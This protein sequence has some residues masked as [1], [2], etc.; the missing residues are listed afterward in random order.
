ML[1]V[2]ECEEPED[3]IGLLRLVFI[4]RIRSDE[5]MEK[6]DWF[7]I[8]TLLEIVDV[9]GYENLMPEQ[10]VY[11]A[12]RFAAAAHVSLPVKKRRKTLHPQAFVVYWLYA[13]GARE[14]PLYVGV[15]QN[16]GK[17][18]AAHRIGSQQTKG[19]TDLRTLRIAVVATV[20][21]SWMDAVEEESRQIEMAAIINPNL[22]NKA[23]R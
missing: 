21:G 2:E 6:I 23:G 20:C 10:I 9:I 5:W 17:R 8:E 11:F 12:K 19:V 7:P 16:I 4:R 22:L 15:T 3:D 14:I 13:E 18:W 1:T